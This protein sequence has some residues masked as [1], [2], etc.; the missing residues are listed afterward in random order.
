M[1]YPTF[2]QTL[3]KVKTWGG[4]RGITINGTAM[5]QA[6]KTQEEA[7]ELLSAI[8]QHDMTEVRDAIGDI[9]V[10]LVMVSEIVGVDIEGCFDAAYQEIKDR[11]G[12]LRADGVFVKETSK[13]AS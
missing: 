13:V 3:A 8:N 9:I 2:Q 6:I 7:T 11:K 1:N 10:T 5:G 4:E 12:Y